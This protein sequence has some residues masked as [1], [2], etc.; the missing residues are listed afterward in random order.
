MKKKLQKFF[1]ISGARAD[2]YIIK[3]LFIYLNKFFKSKI[4]LHSDNYNLQKLYKKEKIFEKKS[5][6]KFLKTN[7]GNS[8]N[9][10]TLSVSFSNQVKKLSRFFKDENPSI[11][12]LIGDRSETLAAAIA[13]TYNQIPILHIHGGEVSFGSIDE[14]FR[15]CISKLSNF[16]LVSHKDYKKRLIQ[17]GENKKNIEVIGSLSLDSISSQTIPNKKD[18]FEKNSFLYKKFILVSLNSSSNE[19]NIKNLSHKLFKALDNFKNIMKV[20]TFP[21]SDL[22]NSYISKEIIKRKKRADY[23]IFKSLENHY[24]HYLKYC[25]FI[26]GNSSSGII[27]AP[28]FNK[29]FINIGERQDGRLYSK[30][31]TIKIYDLNTL[32]KVIQNVLK[33]KKKIVANNL[34]YKKN[35][36]K[37]ALKFIKKINLK[38]INYKKFIDLKI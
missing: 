25:Q 5:Q 30:T 12:I 15:H 32:N 26:I 37:I 29:L 23:V 31:S 8:N 21:N 20:V 2:Y 34:Y 35:S 1:F 19:K 10:W 38:N 28:Y 33:S 11:I 16:H 24:L 4:I 14:K 7:F 36:K 17:L 3:H 27:E 13:A 18:F 22:F 6:Y 9:S